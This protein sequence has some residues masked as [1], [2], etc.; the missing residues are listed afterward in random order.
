MIGLFTIEQPL[1]AV[2][3]EEEGKSSLMSNKNE[4]SSKA[5]AKT[6]ATI[7]NEPSVKGILS[8]T[9]SSSCP[10]KPAGTSQS[11]LTAKDKK[12]PVPGSAGKQ[13]DV[14]NSKPLEEAEKRRQEL[15]RQKTELAKK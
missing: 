8:S 13:Q 5:P 14:Y 12:N 4:K 3:E 9:T 15:L 10:L 11:T 7:I 2:M 6:T 1:V